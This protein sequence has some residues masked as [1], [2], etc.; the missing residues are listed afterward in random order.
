MLFTYFYYRVYLS[1]LFNPLE[2][3]EIISLINIKIYSPLIAYID[4]TF[5]NMTLSQILGIILVISLSI[6]TTNYKKIFSNS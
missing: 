1:C 3:F 6:L 5:T 2:Q 4:L